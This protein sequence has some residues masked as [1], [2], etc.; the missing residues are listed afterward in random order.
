MSLRKFTDRIGN[1]CALWRW[2]CYYCAVWNCFYFPILD[3]DLIVF[4]FRFCIDVVDAIIV[5]YE[6]IVYCIFWRNRHVCWCGFCD[7]GY[8][9]AIIPFWP[10]WQFFKAKNSFWS[11]MNTWAEGIFNCRGYTFGHISLSAR[12]CTYINKCIVCDFN[13]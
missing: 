12:I 6:C 13:M 11:W 10:S 4:G 5:S 1:H 3:F 7:H 2:L 9:K 8:I